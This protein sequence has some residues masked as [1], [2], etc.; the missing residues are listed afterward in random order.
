MSNIN[1]DYLNQLSAGDNDFISEM[2]QTY[3]DE[4]SKDVAD[5]NQ[6]LQENDIKRLGFLAHRVKSAFKM[7]G[8]EALAGITQ[9][10]EHNAKKNEIP[11]EDYIE[12]VANV[13][14][15]ASKSLEEAAGIIKSMQ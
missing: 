4:T 6:A 11:K 5:L 15:I 7:L 10:V 12:D 2:L 13:V 8:L 9:R 14:T 3:I 1:L